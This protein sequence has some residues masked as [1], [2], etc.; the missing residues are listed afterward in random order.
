MMVVEQSKKSGRGQSDG[1]VSELSVVFTVKPGHGQDLR[2]A[3]ERFQQ[4]LRDKGP[5]VH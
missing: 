5:E 3:C 4:M 2:A 1:V